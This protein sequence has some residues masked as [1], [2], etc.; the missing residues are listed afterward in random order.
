MNVIINWLGEISPWIQ[1]ISLISGV[2]YMV[3]QI[4]QHRLMWYVDFITAGAALIVAF[5]NL[6]DGI[7]S[8]LWAQVFINVYFIVMAAIGIFTWKR[9]SDVT[10]EKMHIVRLS[11]KRIAAIIAIILVGAPLICFLLSRT[12]DPSPILDGISLTLCAVAAW[13]LTCSHIENWYLWIAADAVS[14]ILYA[15]QGAWWMAVLYACYTASSFIGI[16]HWK[17]NGVYVDA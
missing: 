4:L 13:L 7:W 11:G 2:I 5:C 3:M 12:N 1:I 15:G 10:G 16:A 6:Q 8:P 9:L 17:R 14:V